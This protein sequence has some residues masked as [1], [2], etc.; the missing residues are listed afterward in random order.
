MRCVCE[1]QEEGAGTVL[2]QGAIP[3]MQGGGAGQ[4]QWAERGL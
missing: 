3:P 2:G 4:R 1:K